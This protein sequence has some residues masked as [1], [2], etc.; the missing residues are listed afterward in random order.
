MNEPNVLRTESSTTDLFC[1]DNPGQRSTGSDPHTAQGA[2]ASFA[3]LPTDSIPNET[4]R[5]TDL[6]KVLEEVQLATGAT[7]AAIALVQ[8]TEMVC[9]ATSGRNAP[10]LRTCLDPGS[11]LTGRCMQT[12]EVQQSFDTETDPRVNLEACRR[13]EV[14]SIVVVPLMES[15]KLVGIFEILSSRSDAFGPGDLDSVKALT[16]RILENRLPRPDVSATQPSRDLSADSIQ[17]EILAR[18]VFTAATQRVSGVTYNSYWMAIRTATI[19]ALCVLLGWMVGNAG[20]KIA[21]ARAE[22]QPSIPQGEI[23]PPVERPAFESPETTT[24]S[25]ST[26]SMLHFSGTQAAVA[27]EI[28]VEATDNYV[29]TEAKPEYP[30]EAKRRHIQGRV[31]MKVLVG[32]DGVVRDIVVTSGDPQLAEAAT[33]AVR[34]WHFRPHSSEGEPVE[35]ETQI[36][37]NFALT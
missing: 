17:A 18:E 1:A 11:G 37:V 21:V 26:V 25:D 10:A 20:W 35:F 13:L 22:S 9:C 2:G 27:A 36:T 31:V 6:R 24:F 12:R 5:E 29:L 15:D 8:G 7:G 32:T 33:H 16:D 30:K 34:N 23:E 14:R 19:V 3:E 28:S 4:I